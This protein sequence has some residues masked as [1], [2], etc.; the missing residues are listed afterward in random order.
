MPPGICPPN[1]APP[2]PPAL[3]GPC[4]MAH[5]QA[6][7][8]ADDLGPIFIATSHGVIQGWPK[9]DETDDLMTLMR[10]ALCSLQGERTENKFEPPRDPEILF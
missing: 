1:S 4:P 5:G 7:G 2:N 8:D 6:E 3:N 9:N 10:K